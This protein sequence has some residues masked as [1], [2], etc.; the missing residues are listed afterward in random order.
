MKI[1]IDAP[2]DIEQEGAAALAPPASPVGGEL[3]M[4]T[5]IPD[6]AKPIEIISKNMVEL[7]EG[8][9]ATAAKMVFPDGPE[10]FKAM[11][12]HL[13]LLGKLRTSIKKS[14]LDQGRPF[15]DESDRIKAEADKYLVRLVPTEAKIGAWLMDYKR[16]EEADRQKRLAEAR[17]LELEARQRQEAAAALVEEAQDE[18]GFKAAAVKFDDGIAAQELAQE[19]VELVPEATKVKGVKTKRTVEI[20]AIPDTMKVPKA[21]LVVD[22]VKLKKAILDGIVNTEHSWVQFKITETMIGTGR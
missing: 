3:I 17:Q 9:I 20:L 18:E 1:T 14:G 15:R 22:E 7:T 2:P 16:Q 13:N 12:E 19:A 6:L 5:P 21:F 8:A 10:S 4:F 11:Q